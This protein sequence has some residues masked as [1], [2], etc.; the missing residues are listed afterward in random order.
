MALISAF[1]LKYCRRFYFPVPTT[2]NAR[3]DFVS[4]E[5]SITV[6]TLTLCSNQTQKNTRN[7]SITELN[8][9]SVNSTAA[10]AIETN[11]ERYKLN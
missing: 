7:P 8:E 3:I 2:N 4:H 9:T 6:L 5:L 10:T 1:C 11:S